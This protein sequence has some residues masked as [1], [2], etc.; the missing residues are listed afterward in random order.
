MC[1]RLA[2]LS[3]SVPASLSEVA[4]QY[5]L[6]LSSPGAQR[7]QHISPTLKKQSFLLHSLFIMVPFPELVITAYHSVAAFDKHATFV[8]VHQ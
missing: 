6:Q 1:W 2:L 5:R 7:L 4:S 3:L 8:A